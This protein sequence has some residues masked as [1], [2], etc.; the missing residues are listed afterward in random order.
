MLRASGDELLKCHT[1]VTRKE[2]D[3]QHINTKG[4]QC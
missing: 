3:I 1:N 4:S 2:Y